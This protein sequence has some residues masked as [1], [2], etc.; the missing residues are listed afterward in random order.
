MS[1]EGLE[2]FESE[3][4]GIL[5]LMYQLLK[6][7]RLLRSSSSP[8]DLHPLKRIGSLWSAAQRVRALARRGAV[9]VARTQGGWLLGRVALLPRGH[10]CYSK[11]GG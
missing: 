11:P 5:L 3:T 7:G 9:R 1:S 2:V 8:C 6:E 10:A 4:L